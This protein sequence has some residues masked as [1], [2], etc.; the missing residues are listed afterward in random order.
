L[1][2]LLQKKFVGLLCATSLSKAIVHDIIVKQK[3]S[4]Q[5][6]EQVIQRRDCGQSSGGN[7]S[8]D[9]MKKTTLKKHK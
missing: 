1:L 7:V 6:E 9:I 4:Y 2:P 5:Q 3:R 8:S